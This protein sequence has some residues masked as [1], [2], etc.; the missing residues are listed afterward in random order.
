M[1]RNYRAEP[2]AYADV[3]IYERANCAKARGTN[4]PARVKLKVAGLNAPS[5]IKGPNGVLV[6]DAS[7]SGPAVLL[8]S[9]ESGK[10]C[11]I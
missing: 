6:G 2:V 7:F 10:G 8:T 11:Q 9:Y 1:M 4:L 3:E 5:R